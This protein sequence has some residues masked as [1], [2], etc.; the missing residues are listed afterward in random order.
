[1]SKITL[2]V[3]DSSDIYRVTHEGVTDYRGYSGT[4]VILDSNNVEVVRKEVTPDI[5]NGFDFTLAPADTAGLTP[6]TYKMAF[7]IKKIVASVAVFRREIHYDL[8]LVKGRIA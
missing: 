1:M 2:I 4:L 8:T 3:G 6:Y 7:E 5:V